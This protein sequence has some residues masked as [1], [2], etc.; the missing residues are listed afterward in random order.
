MSVW[1]GDPVFRIFIIFLAFFLFGAIWLARPWPINNHNIIY[2]YRG[3]AIRLDK[4]ADCLAIESDGRFNWGSIHSDAALESCLL[5]VARSLKTPK[6]LAEWLSSQ[7]FD[8]G[9]PSDPGFPI[10]SKLVGGFWPNDSLSLYPYDGPIIRL[11]SRLAKYGV[12]V[13]FIF[14]T[15][16]RVTAVFDLSGSIQIDVGADYL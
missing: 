13:P 8:I 5:N 7:G 15:A 9:E 12:K 6:L 14:P 4:S 10:G 16:Y 3:D 1:A 2:N 11:M